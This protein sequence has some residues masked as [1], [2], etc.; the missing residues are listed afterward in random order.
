MIE[1]DLTVA[2]YAERKAVSQHTVLGWIQSGELRAINVARRQG[3]RPHWRISTEA[4]ERFELSRTASSPLP[5]THRR[6]Q[7][8]KIIQ[9]V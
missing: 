2:E 6:K 3:S 9:F 8:E 5:R 7:S 4:V 1:R